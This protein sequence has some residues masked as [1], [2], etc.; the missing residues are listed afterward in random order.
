MHALGEE[1]CWH[2]LM[3][4][5]IGPKGPG[6]TSLLAMSLLSSACDARLYTGFSELDGINDIQTRDQTSAIVLN[7]KS[8]VKD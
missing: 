8:Q 5:L 1:S 4:L 3:T 6:K 2:S 7:S